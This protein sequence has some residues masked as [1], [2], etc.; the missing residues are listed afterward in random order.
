MSAAT[1]PM[2]AKTIN[3][4]LLVLMAASTGRPISTRRAGA[5]AAQ[6]KEA[7]TVASSSSGVTGFCR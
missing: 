1:E 2:P 6:G 5:R 4:F 7:S 3:H